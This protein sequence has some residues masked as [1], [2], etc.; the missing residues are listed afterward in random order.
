MNAALQIPGACYLVGGAVRD[1]LLGL[2]VSERDW[3]V[4]GTTPEAMQAAGFR[5]VG[6]DFPVFLHPQTQEEYALARTERKSAPGYHGFVFHADDSVTLEQDLQRR[7]LTINAIARAAD[8]TLIDPC[9]GQKD[10]ADKV[11][12]HVSD[13]FIEDPVRVLRVARFAARLAPL[14]F[15]VA[16]ETLALMRH[17]VASGEVDHLV[18]ERVFR[19]MSR[20][21]M[22]S[23]RPSVFFE[24]L[25]ACGA[26]ARIL[27]EVDALYGVPQ[28]ADY[29]PE[30][31]TGI[32]TMMCVDA[33]ARADA[34]L[35]VRYMALVHD[36][37]KALTPPGEWPSHR[38]HE[39]RGVPL[40]AAV[41]ERLRVPTLFRALSAIHTREHLNVHRVREF[42]PSTLHDLLERLGGLRGP[43]RERF[44]WILLAC[45]AD[46]RG[47]L[48]FETCAYPQTDYLRAAA[49]LAESIQA[50]DVVADGYQGAAV[51]EQLRRRRIKALAAFKAGAGASIGNEGQ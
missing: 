32:H 23:A 15:S 35:V 16:A 33:A 42:K 2:S 37:G 50:R 36:L 17:M 1:A 11:L 47:R 51:G 18:P 48:G 40:V 26:L 45:E 28:R 30:V 39:T 8:G 24:T 10:L 41:G 31:D 21:L 29:H 46:A 3:V 12:R 4:V 14:G 9:G 22:H 44:E 19:E 13:A 25:R 7:D 34:P 27:P 43:Q 38:M 5:A 6:Q 49:T 20:A